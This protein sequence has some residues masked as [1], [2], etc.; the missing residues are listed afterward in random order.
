MEKVNKND[1]RDL[2]RASHFGS[3]IESGEKKVRMSQRVF[4]ISSPDFLDTLLKACILSE[5]FEI[6]II[7]DVEILSTYGQ[8]HIIVKS[9]GNRCQQNVVVHLH[10]RMVFHNRYIKYCITM[11]LQ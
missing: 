2:G 5:M 9:C 7:Y 6:K 1:E 11:N 4:F 8:M 3:T 10:Y